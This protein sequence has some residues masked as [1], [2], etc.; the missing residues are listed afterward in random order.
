MKLIVRQYLAGLNERDELDAILPDLLN[1]LGLNVFSRPGRGTRQD[2]VDVAAVGKL[3]T[4]KTAEEKVYLFSIKAGNLTRSSWDGD[5]D[6]SLRRSLNEIIDSYIPN[7]FP[8]ELKDKKIV[9]CLCFGGDIQEQVRPLV[10]GYKKE[11]QKR[12]D[13]Y[14]EEWNGDKLAS[15]IQSHFLREQLMPPEAHGLLRKSLALLDEPEASYRHFS[16]LIKSFSA[17]E[18]PKDKVR[19]KIIRQINICL[20][21]L[22][23]WARD[24]GN[25]ESAYLASEIALLHGW[26]IAKN[27]SHG[28][29][30]VARSI[31][32]AFQS[33]LITQQQISSQYLNVK[34][35]PH[36]HK[37]HA[38]SSEVRASCS[39]DINL[40]LFDLLSRI[41]MGGIWDLWLLN[42]TTD[43]DKES[44]NQLIHSIEASANALIN[45]IWNNPILGSPIKDD[46]G[47]D[48]SIAIL[49]LT[50]TN[51]IQELD[52]WLT[53]I[54][55]RSN[56]ALTTNGLYPCNVNSYS[57]LLE[58]PKQE[59]HY[60]E[61]VTQGSILYPL[62]AFWSSI[63]DNE[64]LYSEIQKIKKDHLKHCNFQYWYPDDDSEKHF[65]T[66][67]DLH[68]ATL[69]HLCIEK[70]ASEF[71]E[72]LIKECDKT[73]YFNT[74]SAIENNFPPLILIACRHYRIPIPIQFF[75][76]CINFECAKNE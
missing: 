6:Q 33:L 26:E 47:I 43:E 36:T 29:T 38:I 14:F 60:V 41:A 19:L 69:S 35:I 39:L 9:I 58:H 70:T 15:L 27:Y 45:L 68:G 72:Q 23:S 59:P 75:N 28:S 57:E 32:S 5:T 34:I 74:L 56:F 67:T 12:S 11:A 51:H 64:Q 4:S 71:K 53:E 73:T 10:E 55:N 31:I 1:E 13:V 50:L 54:I 25:I 21:I 52:T 20:W 17:S 8:S 61:E 3:T 30:V 44:K 65:Y 46:Q 2:G 66:N 37:L 24:I 16:N 40:R 49:F 22:F 42:L 76:P 18:N 48:I 63:V 62:V 7:R